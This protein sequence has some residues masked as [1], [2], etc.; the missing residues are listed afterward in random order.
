MKKSN[1]KLR[2]LLKRSLI[3]FSINILLLFILLGRLYFLQ[4]YQGGKYALLSDSNR[5]SKRLTAPPRGTIN[6]RN[7]IELAVNIQNFQALVEI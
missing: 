1:H 4:I 7:G 6:D 3:M 5:I 2:I